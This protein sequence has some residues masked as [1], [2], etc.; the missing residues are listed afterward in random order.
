MRKRRRRELL[1]GVEI[2]EPECMLGDHLAATGHRDDEARLL[3]CRQLKLDPVSDVVDCNCGQYFFLCY[4]KKTNRHN[5][6][7][8]HR[9]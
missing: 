6:E 8:M 1:A 9:F 5:S 7:E 2:G 3:R 4:W